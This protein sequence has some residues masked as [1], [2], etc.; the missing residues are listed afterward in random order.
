MLDSQ[1]LN[2]LLFLLYL[3][4]DKVVRVPLYDSFLFSIYIYIYSFFFSNLYFRNGTREKSE[5]GKKLSH[6]KTE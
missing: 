2:V 5:R 1:C 6:Y 4:L 3:E